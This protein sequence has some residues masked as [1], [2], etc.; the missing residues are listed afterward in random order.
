MKEKIEKMIKDL[1]ETY[2]YY[3]EKTEDRSYMS[4]LKIFEEKLHDLRIEI[5]TLKIVLEMI[6]NEN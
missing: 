3:L 2:D 4:Q 1:E 6:E 5:N